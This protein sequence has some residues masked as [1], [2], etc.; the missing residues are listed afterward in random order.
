MKD[1]KIEKI[2]EQID[3]INRKLEYMG[4]LLDAFDGKD[5]NG[6]SLNPEE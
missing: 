6:S 2:F 4:E 1:D 3:R 5:E